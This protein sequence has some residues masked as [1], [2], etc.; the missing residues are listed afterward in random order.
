M[1][2]TVPGTKKQ[3][4]IDKILKSAEALID[5]TLNMV[6][7]LFINIDFIIKLLKTKN[8]KMFKSYLKK[9]F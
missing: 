1:Y 3:E 8:T 7:L 2:T 4:V 9:D 5:F 6:N